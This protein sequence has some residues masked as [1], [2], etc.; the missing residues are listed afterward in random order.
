MGQLLKREQ[1]STLAR[2]GKKA[3]ASIGTHGIR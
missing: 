3:R 1:G 2:I